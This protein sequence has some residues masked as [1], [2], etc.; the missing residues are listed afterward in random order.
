MN[1]FQKLKEECKPP[2]MKLNANK[3]LSLPEDPVYYKWFWKNHRKVVVNGTEYIQKIKV[4]K[5]H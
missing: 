2:R 3:T 5:I 1:N 4:E